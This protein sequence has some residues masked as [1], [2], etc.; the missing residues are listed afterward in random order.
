MV[1]T[2]LPAASEK[3]AP[4]IQQ[5]AYGNSPHS[6]SSD[7]Q[8]EQRRPFDFSLFGGNCG[9]SSYLRQQHQT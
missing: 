5:N 2:N 6:P 1:P 3:K 4:A 8:D 7:D 9:E